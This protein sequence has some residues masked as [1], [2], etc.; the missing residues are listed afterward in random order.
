MNDTAAR[1]RID[2]LIVNIGYLITVDATRRV[3]TDAAI[4][5]RGGQIVAVGKE[6][7]VCAA[8]EGSEVMSRVDARRA[9][10][11]PGFIDLHLH[12]SF[13]LARGLADE[14]NARQFLVDR[15]YPYE[16]ALS[17]ADVELSARLAARE[18]LRHGTTCFVDPGNIHPESTLAGIAPLGIRSVL[19]RSA[20]D[21]A[22]SDF[23]AIP[24]EMIST[25]DTAVNEAQSLIDQ[26]RG[27]LDGRIDVSVAFRGLNNTSDELIRGLV[28]VSEKNDAMLQMHACFALSTHDSSIAKYGEPEVERLHRLGALGT[29]TLIAH[30]GWLE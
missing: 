11:T 17:R 1:G 15:M 22:G 27:E 29:R 14:A 24:K 21:L 2:L 7:E 4:A 30:A 13:Q 20:F 23:G 5:V 9:V 3:I 6:S 8:L 19:A 25:P 16:A 12:S 18:M 10:V 28:E 26:Y